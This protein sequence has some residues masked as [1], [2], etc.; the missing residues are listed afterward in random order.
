MSPAA[1]A[2]VPVAVERPGGGRIRDKRDPAEADVVA[3]A[4]IGGRRVPLHRVA[5]AAWAALVAAARAAGFPA[6][7]LLPVSGYRSSERQRELFA[8]AVRRY[9]NAAS[10][11]RWVAPPGGSAHQSGRAIDLHLGPRNDSSNIVALRASPAYR[12]LAENAP[13]FGFVPYDRE[14]WHWEYNPLASPAAGPPG[15]GVTVVRV[16]RK[17]NWPAS[18]EEGMKVD[19]IARFAPAGHPHDLVLRA[20]AAAE[21]GY[22]T[23][24][25]YDRGILSWGIMQWTVHQGSLQEALGA[26]REG[27]VARGQGALW[28]QL[29]PALD[30]RKVGRDWQLLH[31][32]SPVTGIPALRVLFRGKAVPGEYDEATVRHWATIFARAGRHPAIQELQ[33]EHARRVVDRVLDRDLGGGAGRVRAYV[34]ASPKATVLMFG[35]WTNNPKQS[36]VELRRAIDRVA[37]RFGTRDVL[38]WPA[39]A[40]AVLADEFERVLRASRFSTWGDVKAAAAK[41]KSRTA[42]LMDDFRNA[43]KGKP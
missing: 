19:G 23:V 27:L 42:K 7:L 26:I 2:F 5:A 17:P 29:F 15:N 41:R 21:G 18:L 13:R 24:N 14:P 40:P 32:G 35:M 3:V 9:G 43:M 4:G 1:F 28:V 30:V 38:R 10:A 31:R 20:A 33:R 25:M 34:G 8:T 6:P 12:W 36:Y 11:R 39:E 22:D 37:S 16:R